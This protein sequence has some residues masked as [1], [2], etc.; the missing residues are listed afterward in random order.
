MRIRRTVSF[1][2][3]AVLLAAAAVCAA[4]NWE[5]GGAAGA[6]IARGVAISSVTAGP[7]NSPSFAVYLGQDISG[8]LGGE[9]RYL[10]RPGD[11]RLASA[12]SKAAF[13]GQSHLVHYD[14]LLYAA[15]RGARLRPYLAG[16]AGARI[17]RGTGEEAAYQPLME[18]ALLTRTRQVQPLVSLG[19]GLKLKTAGRVVFRAEVRDYASPFPSQVIAP[20][21]GRK[22]EGWLHDIVPLG[23]VGWTF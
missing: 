11:L 21:P 6:G 1:V 13:G 7:A 23:G 8:R 3:G 19:A 20:A 18:Y 9:L 4:Q 12:G 16:G 22:A 5:A 14:L 17:T 2:H 15:P 10:F